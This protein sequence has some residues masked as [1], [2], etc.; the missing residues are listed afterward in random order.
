MKYV[1]TFTISLS[2]RMSFSPRKV[3]QR[4]SFCCLTLCWL[5]HGPRAEVLTVNVGQRNTLRFFVSRCPYSL[6]C[7]MTSIGFQCSWPQL[8]AL[9]HWHTW[10]GFGARH[11]ALDAL[12]QRLSTALGFR[13]YLT[14]REHRLY[15]NSQLCG[16]L[17]IAFL[18]LMVLGVNFHPMLLKPGMCMT[19]SGSNSSK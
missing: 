1:S 14:C 4:P 9:L 17:A 19:N 13:A 12:A 8:M 11:D 15:F 18:R 7:F 6:L 3:C 5:R 10:D 2:S 16:A